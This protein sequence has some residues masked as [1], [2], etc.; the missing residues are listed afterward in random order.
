MSRQQFHASIGSQ[1]VALDILPLPGGAQAIALLMTLDEG[2][3]FNR[4][5]GGEL[6]EL[7]RPAAPELV[8][9]PVTHRIALAV[10]FDEIAGVAGQQPQQDDQH[11]ANQRR[12]DQ[13][14][15]LRRRGG[16]SGEGCWRSCTCC[17]RRPWRRRDGNHGVDG[18]PVDPDADH[19]GR[20]DLTRP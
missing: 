5:A 9:A 6:A 20:C 14:P 3:A 15:G 8:L 11:L 2:W 13:P 4:A 10:P 1:T 18:A 19:F 16:R 7:L 17:A 12:A